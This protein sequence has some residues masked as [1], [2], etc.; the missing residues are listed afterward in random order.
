MD[1]SYLNQSSFDAANCGLTGMDSGLG[2]PCSIPCSYP[3]TA[4]MFSQMG[5]GY[6]RYNGVR[7][8][9][10][11]GANPP[12][13]GP[14]GSCSMVP[15]PRDHHTQPPVFGSDNDSRYRQ[16][17]T[18]SH[19]SSG[20]H[21][22]GLPYKMYQHSHDSSV[23]PEKRKQRR[24]RTTFTSAQLK[25][26]EKAFAETH[27]PDIYTREEIAMKTDLTEA[28]VQVWFQNRRAKFRKMERMKQS[29]SNSNSSAVK[30]E[31]NSSSGG[32]SNGSN[33]SGNSSN[34]NGGSG[35][36]AN[37]SN[38]NNSSTNN[39]NIS[40]GGKE[41]V[42]SSSQIEESH[43]MYSRPVQVHSSQDSKWTSSV[44]HNSQVH[45]KQPHNVPPPSLHGPFSGILG[46]PG[47]DY[48]PVNSLDKNT[49]LSSGLLF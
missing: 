18:P 20:L 33:N 48:H 8:F 34:N 26:L 29:Q 9:P 15:R 32:S 47:H 42:K 22:L 28:R 44:T 6:G 3:D 4:N 19:S 12:G 11:M 40:N 23:S 24:I 10:T 41:K 21:L 1:Y 38:N 5:Q 49:P 45:S 16:P 43:N 2:N 39:N 31:P 36:S 30:Q 17:Y 46:V 27:Y 37:N 13:L 14:A 35:G 25:E 7:S